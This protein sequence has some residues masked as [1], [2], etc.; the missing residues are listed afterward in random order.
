LLISCLYGQIQSSQGIWAGTVRYCI[1]IGTV[2]QALLLCGLHSLRKKEMPVILAAVPVF[3]LTAAITILAAQVGWAYFTVCFMRD[4][5][6]PIFWMLAFA[7]ERLGAKQW[8][9]II[10]EQ[11]VFVRHQRDYLTEITAKQGKKV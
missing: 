1:I 2:V 4:Y 6:V 3:L 5:S 8:E 11:I 10:S 7:F 9:Q